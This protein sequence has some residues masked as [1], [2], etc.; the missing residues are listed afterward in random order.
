M[1][2]IRTAE[3]LAIGSELLTPFRTDTN[4]LFL[5]SRLN[6][7][8]IDVRAGVHVGECES[9]GDDIAGTA[10]ACALGKYRG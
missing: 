10:D 2:S 3:I 1:R 5:T 9:R 7:L 6:E 8:G 4:S